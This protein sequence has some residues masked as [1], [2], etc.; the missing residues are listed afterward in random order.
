M[1]LS[2]TNFCSNLFKYLIQQK[3]VQINVTLSLTF[4]ATMAALTSKETV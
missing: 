1:A 4:K 2:S 3:F